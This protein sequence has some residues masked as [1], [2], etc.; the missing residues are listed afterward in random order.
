MLQ[1]L[2][3]VV[4]LFAVSGVAAPPH[5]HADTESPPI[6]YVKETP[7]GQFVF[8]MLS[9]NPAEM[10]LL[11]LNEEAGRE[12]AAIRANYSSSGLYRADDTATPLW[13][14]DWYAHSVIP[15]SD[16]VHLVREGPWAR[17]AGDEG[18]A[19]FANGELLRAYSVSQVAEFPSLMP[20]TVSHFSWR[21]ATSFDDDALT[22]KIVTLHDE[23]AVFDVRTG[24][25]IQGR[26]PIRFAML[27]LIP[28]SAALFAIWLL[29]R[30]R[31]AAVGG[32]GRDT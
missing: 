6:S 13:T 24:R 32:H 9:P 21:E 17:S 11:Y 26:S 8:V 14:V 25:I 31:I 28:L 30:R 2:K 1:R 16:G 19:F 23:V 12:V 3:L 5:A 7:D 27:G 29:W 4:C 15:F 10:E 20:H 22:Y 18:V